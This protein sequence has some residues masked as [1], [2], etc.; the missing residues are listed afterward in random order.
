[1]GRSNDNIITREQWNNLYIYKLWH[2]ITIEGF[3]MIRQLYFPVIRVKI[4]ISLRFIESLLFHAC[5]KFGK[6]FDSLNWLKF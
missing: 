1:M 2:I 6:L 5:Y 4:K 3:A